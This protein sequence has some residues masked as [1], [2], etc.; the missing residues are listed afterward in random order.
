MPG[1]LDLFR[2]PTNGLLGRPL[3][4][5]NAVQGL[6]DSAPVGSV[7]APGGLLM[8]P[9]SKHPSQYRVPDDIQN[10]L[11]AGSF[12][13]VVGDVA[14]LA[15]DIRFMANNPE[16]RT[17]G[18]ALLTAMG[19][20]P[21]IPAMTVFHGSPHKFDRFDMSKIG[22]GEGAQAYGHGLYFAES[23]KVA[24]A[25]KEQLSAGRGG[26]DDDVIAR[27]LDA[28]GGDKD[29]A[30]QEFRRRADAIRKTDPQFVV[31]GDPELSGQRF[32][33]LAERVAAGYDPS[34]SL[35]SVDLSDEAIDKM[36]DWDAPLSEQPEAV[37]EAL[38]KSGVTQY[39]DEM[40]SAYFGQLSGE[41]EQLARK[42]AY[43]PEAHRTGMHSRKNW[44]RLDELAPNVDH[45]AIHD[46]ADYA[47]SKT[48]EAIYRDLSGYSQSGAFDASNRLAELGIPGI[49]YFDGSSRAAG[50]G[51]RNFVV[52]DDKL[53][54][55]LK[56][57]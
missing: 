12:A 6:L 56:R 33:A 9:Q 35:Y 10:A 50:E 42:M 44:D 32:D 48:G 3:V 28:S 17:V 36:L 54:K 27:V 1:L 11:T 57:E 47:Q 29:A 14:G 31:G 53:P 24:G 20:L 16:E 40:E 13:P 19:A 41:A 5:A 39:F 25:Y 34:G 52:F 21:F 22:T 8:N 30:A 23:P 46:I 43:G 38:R 2:R 49:K 7:G 51:T 37:R 45:N 18:N 26:S 55:I 15:G 4:D